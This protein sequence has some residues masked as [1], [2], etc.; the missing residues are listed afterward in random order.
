M[1]C[2]LNCPHNIIL[3]K[4]H[5][6]NQ[7]KIIIV[8]N[9]LHGKTKLSMMLVILDLKRVFETQNNCASYNDWFFFNLA[10]TQEFISK[11]DVIH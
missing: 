10:I 1:V 8:K 5:I 7:H 6:D 2:S 11:I 3:T 4:K 9:I